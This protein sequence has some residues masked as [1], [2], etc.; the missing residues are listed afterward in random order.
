MKQVIVLL[1]IV[2]CLALAVNISGQPTHLVKDTVPYSEIKKSMQIF[3]NLVDS[4][5]VGQFGLASVAELNSLKPG[6]QFIN[7]MIGLDDLRNYKT[8]DDVSKLIKEYPSIEVALVNDAGKIR[9]S[10]E[11]VQRDGK[12]EASGYGSTSEFILL[13]YSQTTVGENIVNNGNLVR[14]PSLGV[15]FL[16]VRSR[17]GTDFISLQDN[18]QLKLGRGQ[19]MSASEAISKLVPF[20]RKHNGQPT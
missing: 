7:Y 11:F 18:E 14:I 17:T 2:A 8:G 4:Q 5:H 19:R 6:R 10:I 1:Q 13:S 9:T 20:A 15:S 16:S 12:W 3:V